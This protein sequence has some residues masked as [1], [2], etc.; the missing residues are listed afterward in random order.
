[1]TVLAFMNSKLANAAVTGAQVLASVAFLGAGSMKMLTPYAEL[2]AAP[3]MGWVN[4]FSSGSVLAIGAFEFLFAL[5][6][7]LSLFVAAAKK[8][9]SVFAIGLVGI[10]AGAAVT[11]IGRGEPFVPNLVLILLCA[12]VAYARKD[13]LKTA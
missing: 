4:D 8:W 3:N 5:G 11:H 2:A 10:M 12:A 9:T 1:M 6:L 13:R 7:A